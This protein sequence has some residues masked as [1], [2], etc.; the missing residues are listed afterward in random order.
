MLVG[1]RVGRW[2]LAAGAGLLGCLPVFGPWI[3]TAV[4][5]GITKAMEAPLDW[6]WL[7]LGAAGGG[8]AWRWERRG[9]LAAFLAVVLVLKTSVMPEMAGR[10]TAKGRVKVCV[11]EGASR[12]YRY[13]LYYYAGR[14]APDCLAAAPEER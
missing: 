9:F 1:N 14:E 6:G 11:P 5:V 7:V 8:A 3:P 10:V 12:G 4:E 2:H 13:S